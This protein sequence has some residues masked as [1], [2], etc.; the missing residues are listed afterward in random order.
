MSN[1]QNGRRNR[2]I[3]FMEMSRSA[4]MRTRILPC[5]AAVHLWVPCHGFSFLTRAEKGI[6]LVKEGQYEQAVALFTEAIKCE[7]EDY[8]YITWNDD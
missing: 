8:R 2:N 7:P 4:N 6:K 5:R 1:E 3:L